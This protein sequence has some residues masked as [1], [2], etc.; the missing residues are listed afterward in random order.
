MSRGGQGSQAF[1]RLN[2]A[3]GTLCNL[4]RAAHRCTVNQ[5]TSQAL[6]TCGQSLTRLNQERATRGGGLLKAPRL[7]QRARGVVQPGRE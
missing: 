5:A 3:G 6:S 7:S 2:A 4:R 1:E